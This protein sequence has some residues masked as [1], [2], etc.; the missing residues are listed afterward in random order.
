MFDYILYGVSGLLLLWMCFRWSS[1]NL[2][3]TFFKL[4]FLLS[5]LTNLAMIFIKLGYIVKL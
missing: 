4:L 1:K 3:E 5:G 2:L